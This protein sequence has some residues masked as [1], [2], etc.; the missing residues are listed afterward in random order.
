MKMTSNARDGY[1]AVIWSL[2]NTRQFSF[3]E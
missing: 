3:V 1:G 2:L